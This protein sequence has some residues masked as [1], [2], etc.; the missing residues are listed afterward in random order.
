VLPA[1]FYHHVAMELIVTAQE[2]QLGWFVSH[3]LDHALGSAGPK[4][5]L[6]L[7]LTE[8][9]MSNMDTARIRHCRSK[10]GTSAVPAFI[11]Q[12]GC[13]A[14]ALSG[15]LSIA[16]ALHVTREPTMRWCA[17]PMQQCTFADSAS[18]LLDALCA[19]HIGYFV[20]GYNVN[21]P[22]PACVAA[23]TGL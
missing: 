8:P 4:Q 16:P 23:Q 20:A 13:S 3:G 5:H 11:S 9:R 18:I 14:A 15:R 1:L 6:L 10:E 12:L 22:Q 21:W 2:S 17:A 7:L 19:S